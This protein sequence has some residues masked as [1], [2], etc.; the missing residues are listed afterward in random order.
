MLE[1]MIADYKTKRT[2]SD[3]SF[4]DDQDFDYELWKIC[5]GNEDLSRLHGFIL[6]GWGKV[7]YH[8]LPKEVGA[9]FDGPCG[10]TDDQHESLNLI[11][12]SSM[13]T[14]WRTANKY[15][16]ADDEDQ[17]ERLLELC[18]GVCWH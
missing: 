6:S 18:E 12:A 13:G 2:G 5:D 15:P 11:H 16:Y 8:W 1:E 9:M 14:Y 3:R 7:D 10:A 17:L 4:E